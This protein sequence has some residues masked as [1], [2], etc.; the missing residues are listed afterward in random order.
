MDLFNSMGSEWWIGVV[1]DRVDPEKLGRC[2]VRIF[3]Y[4]TDDLT[5]LPKES[6][7]WA[8]PLTPITSASNSG[9]GSAPIGPIEGTWVMGIFLDGKDK[10]QPLMVGTITSKPKKNVRV[11]DKKEEPLDSLKSKPSNKLLFGLLVQKIFIR[12]LNSSKLHIP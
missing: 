3:G 8:I 7:P 1:E 2:R 12:I 4:H 5:I 11:P 10:Q 9:I 6:L